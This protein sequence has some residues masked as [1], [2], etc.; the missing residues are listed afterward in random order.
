MKMLL[1]REPR[2][3][4]SRLGPR[5]LRPPDHRHR[6]RHD[7]AAG[8]AGRLARTATGRSTSC[9]RP[10]SQAN[11]GRTDLWLLDLRRAGAEPVRIASAP[12]H[13]EHDPRFSADGRWLYYLSNA[14]GSDQ[15]W[16]VA[17]P[18]GTPRAGHRLRHRHRRLSC[19]RRPATGSRSGPTATWPAPI[20]T[21]PTSPR[22]RPGQGSGRVYDETFVRHWDTWAEPGV[23]SRIFT[24]PLVDGRPQGAGTPVAP[25]LVGDSP[26]KPFGGA[27]EL[28]WSP[29]GRT[30]YFTLREGGPRPSP[31]RPI[32]T[33]MPCPA[34]GGA[35]P[36]NLTD[37]ND[38][39]RH[40]A[41]PSRRT[42]A[43]S[44]TPR[45][46]GRPTRPT[47]RSS[48]CATSRPARRAR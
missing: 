10:I 17:L 20:S 36:T 31:T 40:R 27:E 5:R 39:D 37:A 47:A 46:R 15:L 4:R 8:G 22:R 24:F 29:D 21:A 43:G 2:R 14:S 35:A 48:S 45:W 16:R 41:R 1:A 3:A 42:A 44:L 32:S 18:G 13:N 38:G 7:A 26:S 25:S 9:A 6:P 30:L 33:S 19:S 11:R 12:E 23:R 34:D 28:A